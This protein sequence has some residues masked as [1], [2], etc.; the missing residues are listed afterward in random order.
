MKK[1]FMILSASLIML[2]LLAISGCDKSSNADEYGV[3]GVEILSPAAGD[4][5]TVGGEITVR[6]KLTGFTF[7]YYQV[8]YY[9]GENEVPASVYTSSQLAT[10]AETQEKDAEFDF[11]VSTVG[12]DSG[13]VDLIVEVVSKDL[14][15][16]TASTSVML[17]MPTSDDSTLDMV[18]AQPA[19][20]TEFRIG[21]VIEVVVNLDGNL[22]LF[23]NL[24]AYLGTSTSAVYSSN[25]A[26]ITKTFDFSTEDFAAGMYSLK[27]ELNMKDGSVKSKT[28][29]FSLVEYIPTFSI[30][31]ASDGYQLK[32]LIQ[33]Y[34]NGYLAVSAYSP[35]P[36]TG[37][38]RV[39]KYDSEG[40]VQWTQNIPGTVGYAESVCEDTEYDKGYVLAG[41]RQN[42]GDKDTWIRKIDLT[43][44]NLIWNKTYGYP[45]VDDGA[46]VI[47]KTVDDGYIIGGYTL[48]IYGTDSLIFNGPENTVRT[49][50]ET[51]YDVRMLKIYSNGNEIWGYNVAYVG[52]KM[53]QDIT[54]HKLE[55]Y[56][57]VR[58]MGDQMITD[59]IAKDDGNFYI[60]GWN[61]WRLYYEDGTDKKDMFF[62][63]VDIFGGYVS[64]MTWA[65]MGSGDTGNLADENDP[66]AGILNTSIVGANHIGDYAEE[67]ISYGFVQSQGGFGGQVVMAGE[68][69]Q[70]DSK[71]KLNDAWIVE[72]GINGDEDGAFWEYSFGETAKNDKAYGIDQTKD[73]GYIVT[74]YTTG[75]DQDTWLYKL[76]TQ[77]SLL[78]SKN[79]G[80]TGNDSGAKVIQTRDGGFI[81]GG[82]VGS[83]ATARTKLIKVNKTGDQTVK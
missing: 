18:I 80:I 19:E 24:S 60:T 58:K 78:W 14:E 77:L 3:I 15:T 5:V 32:S 56:L 39:V 11:E 41:W 61:N 48:N 23:D 51:G 28:L 55:D 13:S 22:T 83:G 29:N 7:E 31:G 71:A 47:K 57:W 35:T 76:D 43:A 52:Q 72:F 8:N 36:T 59:L 2:S 65:R 67:E 44:G 6:T 49:T 66:M 46:T 25:T 21:D 20:S 54:L 74:G 17:V 16:E 42:G 30:D 10:L 12:L 9:F 40:A 26:D 38:T 73:G 70:A 33:T 81:I 45:G 1:L 63:E 68:T 79:L 4:S 50:W 82:N 62:A 37:G 64:G 27:I 69:Y 75:T 53:W 34:D